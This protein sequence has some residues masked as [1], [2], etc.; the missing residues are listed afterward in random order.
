MPIFLIIKTMDLSILSRE[1]EFPELV[2]KRLASAPLD[3]EE[4][5]AFIQKMRFS[6]HPWEGAGILLPLFFAK[7]QREEN[8]P[9]PHYT[10]LLNK[11]SAIV[12]QPGDLC[13]PGGGIKPTDKLLQKILEMALLLWIKKDAWLL[14]QQ[15][16]KGT[17]KK[18][19][20]ILSNALRESWEEI[21]LH[22]FNIEF[23]GALPAYRLQSRRWIMFPVVGRVKKAWRPKLSWEVEK[24]IPIPLAAFFEVANYAVYSLE[25]P[26]N[27]KAEGIPDPWEFPCFV[28]KVNGAEEILWG[29]TYMVI[30]SFFQI[31]FPF[32]LPSPNGQRIIRRP[33]LRNYFSGSK[34]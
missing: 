15:R 2:R 22:P 5:F 24:I 19:L 7:E 27:L 9:I 26:D 14:A 1:E 12:Q 28:Y 31:I 33:L 23:L 16:G 11:R 10:F 8:F 30:R 29:A 4:Q 6:S 25:I 13:A 21:R 34:G 20:L 3:Y 32:P 17:Y 18:I